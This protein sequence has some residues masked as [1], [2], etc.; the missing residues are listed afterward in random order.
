MA[1]ISITRK[2]EWDMG[3]RVTNHDSKCRNFHGHRYVAYFTITG[4]VIE[5]RGA[6]DEGMVIDFGNVKLLLGSMIELIDHSMMLWSQDPYLS[7]LQQTGT[8]IIPVPFIPTAE[9]IAAY[10]LDEAQKLLTALNL[11]VSKVRVYETPNCYA[12]ARP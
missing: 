2:F 9:N 7:T 8:R 4:P 11:T 3:H 10:L 5:T 12:D 1:A 6:S